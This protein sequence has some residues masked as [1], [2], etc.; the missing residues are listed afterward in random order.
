M[1]GRFCGSCGQVVPDEALRCPSCGELVGGLIGGD[2]AVELAREVQGALGPQYEVQERIGRGGYAVVFK[3]YDRQLDRDLAAKVLLPDLAA[4]HELAERFRRE[5]RTAARLNHPNIVPIFFVPESGRLP[6]Y[7]MPLVSGESLGGRLRREGQLALRVALGIAQDVAAALDA[8]HAQGVVHRDVKPDNVLLEFGSG[9]SLL[10]D[11]GI[12]KAL[13]HDKQLTASGVVIGTPQ[14]M[15]P[16]QAAG[17]KELD[18]RADVYSL[19]AVVFEM[20]AGVPPFTGATTQSVLAG[21]MSLPVPNLAERRG[22]VSDEAAQAVTR[23]L[24]KE[25]DD[26]FGGAGEFV[27]ALEKALDKRSLRHSGGAV[28]QQQTASDMGLFRSLTSEVAAGDPLAALRDAVDVAAVTEAAAAARQSA[29]HAAGR[30]DVEGTLGAALALAGRSDETQ[31]ALR[32]PVRAALLKL[33]EETVVVETLAA[34]WRAGSPERQAHV[35]HALGA[36]MP[37]ARDA[38]IQLVRRDK[39]AEYVLLADRVGALDSERA[40]RLAQD[41]SAA[42]V[43]AFLT[44]MRESLRPAALVERWLGL[45]AR[46]QRPEVRRLVAETA[47]ARG[48]TVAE[49]VG[50]LLA[51]DQDPTVRAAALRAMG[52]SKR[53]EAMSELVRALA[54]GNEAEQ[55]AAVEALGDLGV[56]EAVPH[57]ERVLGRKKLLRLERGALQHAAARALVALPE[58]RGVDVLRGLVNDR[59]PVIAD[60]ARRATGQ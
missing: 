3:V 9:R 56:G 10:M 55:I 18:A 13:Q 45:A 23:A 26:R 16:E 35:E 14:Y 32:Q 31:P 11:F 57:L 30:H 47:Q 27:A 8:A 25:P 19:A 44:A 36:L 15:S 49:R 58:G 39:S 42:V 53:R 20:L 51:A 17:L 22:D 7:V 1:P 4:M 24:A 38:L 34:G 54:A 2:D 52:R 48:G 29:I 40:E 46:H 5:A 37:G 60:I 50:R 28:L 43:Q 41:T 12:A 6:C 21:H 59:D 33:G